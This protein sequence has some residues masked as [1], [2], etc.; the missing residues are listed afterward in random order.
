MDAVPA[1]TLLYPYFEVDLANANGKN[2]IAGMHSTAATAVLGRVTIWSNTGLPIYNFNI[3]LT[4]YDAIS[5]DMRSV[6]NGSLPQTASAGQD[7]TDVLSPKGSMS[8]DINFAS[9]LG[10]AALHSGQ[11]LLCDG[12]AEHAD[13]QGVPLSNSR[14]SASAP[15]PG[16]TS[17]A[18]I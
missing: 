17:P 6:L 4:G 18:A 12:H 7:P 5:F 16:T 2:T 11:R 14:A 10:P 8:Q 9:L 15:T 1:A 3:Y 13:R